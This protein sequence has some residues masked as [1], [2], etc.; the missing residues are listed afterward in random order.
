MDEVQYQLRTN[1]ITDRDILRQIPQVI[2]LDALTEEQRSMLVMHKQKDDLLEWLVSQEIEQQQLLYRQR[3]FGVSSSD[4]TQTEMRK[5]TIHQSVVQASADLSDFEKEHANII[6]PL[7]RMAF[8]MVMEVERKK[9]L[10]RIEELR[11]KNIQKNT[12]SQSPIKQYT[13]AVNQTQANKGQIFQPA[14]KKASEGNSWGKVIVLGLTAI[15]IIF[16]CIFI[17]TYHEH[18]WLDATCFAP[19]TCKDCGETSGE[20]RGHVW[21]DATCLVEKHCADCGKTEG[22]ALGHSWTTGS[23]TEAKKC[24]KCGE[25]I[26]LA[27]PQSGRVFIGKDLY[28]GSEISITSSTHEACYIK[29]KSSSGMDVFSFFVRAGDSITV[30]IPSGYYYVYFSYG[31]T[32]YGTKE[33]FGPETTYAKDDE[34]LDFENYTWEYTLTPSYGG[35]FSETPIDAEEFK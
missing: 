7:V 24:R 3:L 17:A 18:S 1:T 15:A 6:K 28:C 10:Q 27:L 11:R 29:L 13:A 14:N 30:P 16:I 9:E 35:N 20:P 19:Q 34:L 8:P 2:K 21:I 31:T 25:M 22:K 12:I 33:L 26:A 32:W 23:A 5:E 4:V